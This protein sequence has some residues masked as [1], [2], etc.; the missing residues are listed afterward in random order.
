MCPATTAAQE[1]SHRR[2]QWSRAPGGIAQ[3]AA[4]A[5]LTLWLAIAAAAG[6]A[7]LP[8]GHPARV[9]E[10]E[11]FRVEPLA[12]PGQPEPA[13]T[14]PIM[15]DDIAKPEHWHAELLRARDK[16]AARASAPG[17]TPAQIERARALVHLARALRVEHA[18]QFGADLTP[19]PAAEPEER[20]A[21]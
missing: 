13:S 1:F 15:P 9:D 11:W 10:L 4:Q 6:C 20:Q 21:A 3:D 8:H 7:E 17:A 12:I 19:A 16:L 18:A 5:N 2:A 14:I